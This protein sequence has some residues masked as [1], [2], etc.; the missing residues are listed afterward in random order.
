M[1]PCKIIVRKPFNP[2]LRLRSF[3]FGFGKSEPAPIQ[4][5]SPWPSRHPGSGNGSCLQ[6][7]ISTL[8]PAQPRALIGGDG[9]CCEMCELLSC[10]RESLLKTKPCCVVEVQRS[11][12]SELKLPRRLWKSLLGF[13][14]GWFAYVI[15]R[16]DPDTQLGLSCRLGHALKELLRQNA[17][18]R[19]ELESAKKVEE[20]VSAGQPPIQRASRRRRCA[21]LAECRQQTCFTASPSPSMRVSR[22]AGM[23]Q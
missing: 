14:S 1:V 23:P 4:A 12:L 17:E 21:S 2:L 13:Q 10:S 20:V 22:R 5:P 18:L 7:R 6:T 16:S 3:V 11:D 8:S 19:A 15:L 9:R